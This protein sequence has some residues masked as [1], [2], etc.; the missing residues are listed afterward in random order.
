M[1]FYRGKMVILGPLKRDFLPLPG[2]AWANFLIF[3]IWHIN[4]ELGQI[5]SRESS[6]MRSY[7]TK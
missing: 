4:D 6:E 1:T 5:L 2:R 3:Q 7:S